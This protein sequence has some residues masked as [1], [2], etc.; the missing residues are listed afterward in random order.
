[1]PGLNKTKLT[2]LALI[3][4]ACAAT[5]HADDYKVNVT[6]Q[7]FNVYTVDGKDIVIHTRVC[8]TH[9]KSEAAVLRPDR[10][11]AIIVFGE[12]GEKCGVDEA[13]GPANVAAGRYAVTV[14]HQQDD[15]YEVSGGRTFIKTSYCMSLALDKEAVLLLSANGGGELVFKDDRSRCDVVRVYSKLQ[16]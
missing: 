4:V 11:G 5:A 6:R 14:S 2:V 12:S 1:M 13:Y 16:L 7:A 15:W 8:L 9:A 10:F 3:A